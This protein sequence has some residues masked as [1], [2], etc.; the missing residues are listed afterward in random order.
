MAK[1]KNN[2]RIIGGKWR[3]RNIAVVDAPNLRPTP[4]R[5]RETLFNW[6]APY[7]HD[8]VCLDAFAGS[9]ALGFEA[10]SRGAQS[11]TFLEK[12]Q[13]AYMQL[14]ENKNQ[15]K[16]TE[17][18][19]VKADFLQYPLSS[20]QKFN[21]V[22]LDPP[23]HDGLLEKYCQALQHRDILAQNALIYL[24]TAV[25]VKDYNVPQQWQLE[26]EKQCGDVRCELFLS[27]Y[28]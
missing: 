9:G 13:Q 25:D 18:T 16:A 14:Q 8:A 4:N 22:F 24:E 12:N 10:L 21:L 26:K 28:Q 3:S 15:L 23:F 7:I 6:L 17:A 2:I 11:V 5:V 27:S 19:I 1:T 20:D